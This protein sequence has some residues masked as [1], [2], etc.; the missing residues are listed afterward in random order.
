[1]GPFAMVL[2]SLPDIHSIYIAAHASIV[3]SFFN[4]LVVQWIEQIRPKDTMRVRFSPGAPS[5]FYNAGSK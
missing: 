1:M 2:C 3:Y 4:A 5:G